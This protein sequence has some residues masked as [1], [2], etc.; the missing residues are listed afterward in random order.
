MSSATPASYRAFMA[1]AFTLCL[2]LTLVLVIGWRYHF[3]VLEHR[4]MVLALA[5]KEDEQ[6][7]ASG[8][9]HPV[10]KTQPGHP[11]PPLNSPS[12][13][14]FHA[15]DVPVP[16]KLAVEV[17]P[18]AD[19][20]LL[21]QE[22]EQVV[23]KY[24]SASAWQDRLPFVFEPERVRGLMEDYYE[25]Q[26]QIDPSLGTLLD[27]AH[28]RIED[29]EIV[30]LIYRSGR[31]GGRLE[32]TLRRSLTDRLVLDWE[33]FVGY[34]QKSF[35]DLKKSRSTQPVMLR[36]YVTL[37][38][39]H[40]FEFRDAGTHL[41]L[42]VASPDGADEVHAYCLRESIPGR[43]LLQELGGKVEGSLTKNLT[44]WVNYPEKAQSDSCLNLLQ[45]CADGWLVL[46][47]KK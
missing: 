30:V 29:A 33:S 27:Q 37:S 38:D 4:Q 26:H 13:G 36:G 28:Y 45:V 14:R 16:A 35:A 8:S 7:A 24:L 42:K 43:W 9:S 44:L 25:V 31:H 10:E 23:R 5:A 22:A 15:S 2:L 6:R 32:L 47:A 12:P 40:A 3:H 41:A 21:F 19:A 18:L 17:L 1:A 39:H 20:G 46:P 11:A 34:S